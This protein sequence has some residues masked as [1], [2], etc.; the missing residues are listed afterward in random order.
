M[1]KLTYTMMAGA[2]AAVV[3][4]GMD[5]SAQ[6]TGA[7]PATQQNYQLNYMDQAQWMRQ[8]AME[9]YALDKQTCNTLRYQSPKEE[10]YEG[11]LQQA[12]AARHNAG[13]GGAGSGVTSLAGSQAQEGQAQQGSG[14]DPGVLDKLKKVVT[15]TLADIGIGSGSKTDEGQEG[16]G[17]QSSQGSSQQQGGSAQGQWSGQPQQGYTQGSTQQGA[18]DGQGFAQGQSGQP[19]QG[20][21]QGQW[22]GQSQQGYTQGSAQQGATGGQGSAK[23]QERGDQIRWSADPTLAEGGLTQS[24]QYLMKHGIM[25]PTAYALELGNREYAIQHQF[26]KT[27]NPQAYE[28][29]EQQAQTAADTAVKSAVDA[30]AGT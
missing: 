30:T 20:F 8:R 25:N 18:T 24:E 5:S 4:T 11:C 23:G 1:S 7:G 15:N 14:Q 21:A 26:C 17:G 10:E 6:G 22:G 12:E 9:Q 27:L 29:C 2:V 16:Q 19:Q 13:R 28:Q 3:A